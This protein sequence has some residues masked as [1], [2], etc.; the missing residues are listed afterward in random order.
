MQ[1]GMKNIHLFG[2]TN[3]VVIFEES[4]YQKVI[5]QKKKK[6]F[7]LIDCYWHNTPNRTIHCTN[8][9][10]NWMALKFEIAGSRASIFL[11]VPS[12]VQ[13]SR[14]ANSVLTFQRH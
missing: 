2:S 3:S 9:A 8:T 7:R 4:F 13:A 11:A 5:R 6:V 14:R 1:V 12:H 10:Y